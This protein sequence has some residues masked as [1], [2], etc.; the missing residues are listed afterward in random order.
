MI[1][2]ILA[3]MGNLRGG[4]SP[5]FAT[6]TSRMRAEFPRANGTSGGPDRFGAKRLKRAGY[7]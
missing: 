5:E 1:M 6:A 3:P 7:E 4:T 2:A